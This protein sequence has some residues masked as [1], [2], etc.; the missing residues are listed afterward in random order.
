MDHDPLFDPRPLTPRGPVEH[1][2]AGR[3]ALQ[4][5]TDHLREATEHKKFGEYLTRVG[6]AKFFA[7][8]DVEDQ[9]V[10]VCSNVV[11]VLAH[12]FQSISDAVVEGGNL[13]WPNREG[14]RLPPAT[15][16]GRQTIQTQLSKHRTTVGRKLILFWQSADAPYPWLDAEELSGVESLRVLSHALLYEAASVS[17]SLFE[18]LDRRVF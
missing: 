5:A 3:R 1:L 18:A 16:R 15:L 7:L 2:S 9:S 12:V 8:V 4:A 10:G 11:L 6:R 17:R 13:R 14:I